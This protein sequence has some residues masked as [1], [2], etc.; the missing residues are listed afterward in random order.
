MGQEVETG[1]ETQPSLTPLQL[2]RKAW[3]AQNKEV[4]KA[5]SLA[6]RLKDPDAYRAKGRI[7]SK[8]DPLAPQ[9]KKAYKERHPGRVLQQSAEYREK[10]A[11]EIAARIDDWRQRNGGRLTHYAAKRRGAQ[12]LACPKWAD[13]DLIAATYAVA[14]I[15]RGAGQL[16]EVDHVVPLQ[17]S[18]VCGLHCEANLEVVARRFNRAKSNR[19]WPDMP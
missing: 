2:Y 11:Y 7:R 8:A 4:V 10:Y 5:R 13:R 18:L 17:H 16:V 1:S 12:G 15:Y 3:Y 6:Q 14:R 9:R 19:Y